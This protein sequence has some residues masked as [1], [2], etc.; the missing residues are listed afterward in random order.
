MSYSVFLGKQRSLVFPVMCNAFATIDYSDNIVDS[1]DDIPYGIWAHTGSFTFEAVI[2]PYDINGFGSEQDVLIHPLVSDAGNIE[3]ISLSSDF[4]VNTDTTKIM[5]A[6][7]KRAIA[8]GVAPNY[9]SQLYLSQAN[10]LN[11]IMRIFHSSN[12]QFSLVND[13]PHSYNQ[14][15]RYR[16]R[17]G[18]KLGTSSMENFT[19]DVVISPNQVSQFT[20]V[21]GLGGD[22]FGGINEDGEIEF[23]PYTAI[24]SQINSTDIQVVNN[25]YVSA[26]LEVFHKNSSGEFISLG[27]IA[28]VVPTNIV[29]LSTPTSETLTSNDVL[30]ARATQE[31]LYVNN[32]FHVACSY[33]DI[34]KEIKMYLNGSLIFTGTHTQAD[35]FSFS[36]EDMFIGANG[37]GQ[38]GAN[39]AILN[40][41]FMG[42]MHEMC[43]ISGAKNEFY[44]ISNLVPNYNDTLF[45]LRFEEVDE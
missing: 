28:D 37:Q 10:R 1:A 30:Y 15:S 13:T 25:N 38:T 44:G 33:D 9:P 18:I 26:G 16:L 41:Q 8:D 6:L 29:R 14:P 11:H 20:N 27:T 32:T 34:T 40:K 42:E 19:T 21:A 45:Y 3:K 36:A 39:T 17:T 7:S 35:S 4:S 12:F 43:L 2:T 5:P 24:N 23:L 31:P 22:S